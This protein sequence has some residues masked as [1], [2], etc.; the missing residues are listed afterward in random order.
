M[1][2]TFVILPVREISQ[3]KTESFGI[4]E[5]VLLEIIEAAIARS[6]HGS[7]IFSHLTMFI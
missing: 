4:D 6:I 1:F 5:F 3:I 7:S 2:T